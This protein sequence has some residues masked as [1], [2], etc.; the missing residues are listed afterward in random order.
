MAVYESW[1]PDVLKRV[2][3]EYKRA[4][5]AFE[6]VRPTRQDYA[7][8]NQRGQEDDR[9]DA[10]ALRKNL[11]VSLQKGH[12][13][14][15]KY[16][17][18][19]GEILI[20]SPKTDPW[21][22][23]PLEL[24]SRAIRILSP[25]KPVRIVIYASLQKRLPPPVGYAIGP[26]HINGGFTIQCDPGT[27]VIYRREEATRVLIHELFHANCSDPEHASIPVLEGDTEAWAEILL[28]AMKARGHKKEFLECFEKQMLYAVKQAFSC[29]F[30]HGVQSLKDYSWRYL[31]GRIVA[32]VALGF[33]VPRLT[34]FEAI[35]PPRTLRLT[36]ESLG[37]N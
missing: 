2:E 33:S 4:P 24:W 8:A 23:P 6:A 12:A 35:R 5:V 13:T 19:L 36:S 18:S 34:E 1:L 30:Y 9:F 7:Y 29:R 22:D 10:L 17:S 11:T 26:E 15:E 31:F 16:V 28:C 21:I 37:K 20:V 32:W 3:K 27:I 25:T 14:L